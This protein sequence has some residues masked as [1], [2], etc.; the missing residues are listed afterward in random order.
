[1]TGRTAVASC[2]IK[3][4]T[5]NEERGTPVRVDSAW[6]RGRYRWTRDDFGVGGGGVWLNRL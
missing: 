3:N 4:E 5:A 1:M 6:R 2:R